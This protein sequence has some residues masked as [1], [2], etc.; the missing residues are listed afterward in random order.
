M[1]HWGLRRELTALYSVFSNGAQS[2]LDE[3]AIQYPDFALWQRNSAT[4]CIQRSWMRRLCTGA[5][6]SGN[7]LR[8]SISHSTMR[9]PWFLRL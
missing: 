7:L 9:D 4:A 8:P 3:V 5:G 2:P 1:V 6:S